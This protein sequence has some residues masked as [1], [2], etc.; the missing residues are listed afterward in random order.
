MKIGTSSAYY[1]DNFRTPITLVGR[2]NGGVPTMTES[3]MKDKMLPVIRAMIS[4]ESLKANWTGN[5]KQSPFEVG[6]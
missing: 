4:G 5:D 3:D 1:Y 2:L 6:P